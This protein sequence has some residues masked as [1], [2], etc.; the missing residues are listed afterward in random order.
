TAAAAVLAL[1]AGASLAQTQ[2]TTA[3]AAPAAVSLAS[4]KYGTWGFDKSGM[5]PSVK[6]GDDFFKFANGKWAER[7]AIPSDRV[8]FGNFD[9]LAELSENR[10]RAILDDAAAGKVKDPDAAK[11]AAAY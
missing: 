8:R 7:T 11:I 3:A 2:A 6:P 10:V 1:G 4:P 9:V 5:D